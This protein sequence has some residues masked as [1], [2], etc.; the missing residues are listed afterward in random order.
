KLEPFKPEEARKARA[1]AFIIKPFE[2]SELLV[3]LTKLED[4]IVPKS[5][6]Y[7]QRRFAKAIAAVEESNQGDS[8][9]DSESGWKA[10]LGFPSGA[11]NPPEPQPEGEVAT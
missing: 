5:E 6:P 11:P 8:F 4:K 2:A 9:G 1:D 3:T 10:R 7:K